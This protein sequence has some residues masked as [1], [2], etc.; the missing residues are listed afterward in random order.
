MGS[1]W[2]YIDKVGRDAHVGAPPQ[3]GC[4]DR[5]HRP[6]PPSEKQPH[7]LAIANDDGDVFHVNT[8][9]GHNTPFLPAER[10]LHAETFVPNSLTHGT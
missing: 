4:G 3:S 10:R 6:E 5:R 7:F 9:E 8:T 1:R 2:I